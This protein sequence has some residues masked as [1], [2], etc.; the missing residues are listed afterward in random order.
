MEHMV[1]LRLDDE[2][3]LEARKTADRRCQS[4]TK[5]FREAIASDIG[6]KRKG[7]MPPAIFLSGSTIE[8]LREGRPEK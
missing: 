3:I 8:A 1:Q 2:L 7:K 6:G 4:L 5:L